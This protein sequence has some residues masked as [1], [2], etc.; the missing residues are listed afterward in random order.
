MPSTIQTLVNSYLELKAQIEV[1]EAQKKQIAMQFKEGLT[2]FG[3]DFVQVP[4]GDKTYQLKLATRETH[5][6][7]WAA[8]K[9]VHPELYAEFVTDGSSTYVDV[10]PVT[11]GAW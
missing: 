6:C 10:R 7:Q 8:F 2:A 1:L 11:N 9:G 5:S 3:I 4:V